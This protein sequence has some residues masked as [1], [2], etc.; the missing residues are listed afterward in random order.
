M[1]HRVYNLFMISSCYVIAIAIAIVVVVVSVACV[2]RNEN[3][4]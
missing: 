2:S 4:L 3:M 1:N